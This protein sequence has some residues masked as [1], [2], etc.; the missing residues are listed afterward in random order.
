MPMNMIEPMSVEVWDWDLIGDDQIG[1]CT[2]PLEGC[3]KN[4][5]TWGVNQ[6]F[7][8]FGDKKMENKYKTEKFG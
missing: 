3:L 6:L 5:Q 7:P 2:I 1:L 8:L 4:P